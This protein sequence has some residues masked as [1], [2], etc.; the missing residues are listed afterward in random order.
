M[1]LG[2]ILVL[3]MGV[4]TSQSQG[5]GNLLAVLMV[6]IIVSILLLLGFTIYQANRDQEKENKALA[7]EG[8]YDGQHKGVKWLQSA[9]GVGL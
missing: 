1:L 9:A 4:L 2:S 6:L 7:R 8:L 5:D 3:M